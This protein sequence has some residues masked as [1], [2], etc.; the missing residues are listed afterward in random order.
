VKGL[1]WCTAAACAVFWVLL[2]TATVLYGTRQGLP[3]G[4][5]LGWNIAIGAALG[6]TVLGG[7][8]ALAWHL[9]RSLTGGP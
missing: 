3:Q 7:A 4:L 1:I 6:V 9:S 5:P 8:A 2:I